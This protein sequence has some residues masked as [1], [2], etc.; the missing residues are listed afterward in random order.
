[1]PDS[2]WGSGIPTRYRSIII[3]PGSPL[4]NTN[5]LLGLLH[6]QVVPAIGCTEPVSIAIAVATARNHVEGT[7]TDVQVQVS[8]NIFKNGMRVGI[9]GTTEKGIAFATALALV[10]GDPSAGLEIFKD[11][12]DDAVRKARELLE[13]GC[14]HIGT[15]QEETAFH[16]HARVATEHDVAECVIESTHTNVT[17]IRRNGQELFEGGVNIAS[18]G[19][20]GEPLEVSLADICSFAEAVD[21]TDL[22]FLL[23]GVEMNLAIAEAGKER[24]YSSG[25]GPRLFKLM[26]MGQL[27]NDVSNTIKAYTASA[28][29][30]RMGGSELPVMSSSGSGNQGIAA[31]IPC[32]LLARQLNCT[33]GQLSVALAISH[34]VT[35]HIKQ[36]TGRLSP[37]CGCAVAAGIGAATGMTWLQGG[38]TKELLMVID[39]MI[40]SLAGMVCDG[41]K[42]GCSYKLATAVGEAYIQSLVVQ[43]FT[44]IGKRDGIVGMTTE[45]TVENLGELCKVGMATVDSTLVH[46]LTEGIC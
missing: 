34:L 21:P 41:A 13:S 12:D 10:A 6:A 44:S 40:G 39:N 17:S 31:S 14:I 46:I 23:E 24:R 20:D 28:C 26:A 18:C 38:R 35:Y 36:K 37:V 9:P 8:L 29:D 27:S 11:V 3:I 19:G 45:E 2:S 42:G 43:D 16:V 32:A 7:I 25:L 30:A 5:K 22:E 1:M 15:V 4:V 33:D